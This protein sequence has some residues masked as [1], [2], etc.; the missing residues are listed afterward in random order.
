MLMS[1]SAMARLFD[2]LG[3]DGQAK[4]PAQPMTALTIAA[5]SASVSSSSKNDLSTLSLSAAAIISEP[6]GQPRFA[7]WK[8]RRPASGA[9]GAKHIERLADHLFRRI[10]EDRLRSGIPDRD[11]VVLV[12]TDQSISERHRDALKAALRDAA[13]QATKID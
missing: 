13:E 7:Q 9:A 4:R 11:Q 3:D 6:R 10:A 2:A 1:L 8:Q 5:A 12:G